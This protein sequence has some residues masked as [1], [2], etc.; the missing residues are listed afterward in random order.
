MD[1]AVTI[2]KI[3]SSEYDNDE[4]LELVHRASGGDMNSL[5][6]F[7]TRFSADIFNFPIKVFRLDEDAASDF[8]LYA[9]ERL[10]D[11]K[12]FKSFQGR[13]SFRTWFY[14]VLRNLLIDWMRTVRELKTVNFTRLDEDGNL[15]RSIE[16]TPDPRSI[17]EGFDKPQVAFEKILQSLGIESRV[18]FKLSYIY[19]LDLSED[20]IEYLLGKT[21]KGVPDL[22]K[23]I[24]NLKHFLSEK[25]LKNHEAEDKIT[26]LYLAII[27]LKARKEQII[28]E[29]LS[30]ERM[31]TADEN[32][33]LERIDRSLQKK[34]NQREKLLEKKG[35]G[36]FIV[37]TPY[38]YIS[39]LLDIPE[40]SISVQMMRIL[41]KVQSG[42]AASGF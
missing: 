3:R 22:L 32:F 25:E 1:Q 26:S 18:L 8:F 2:E 9:Y 39:E 23:Y 16:N 34:Y 33:E 30:M 35:K 7:F 19:Y 21:R 24:A 41:E 6:T 28:K 5:K 13:S 15:I 29:S 42:A 37:R 40:G 12:R 36:R 11:G 27:E 20:E 31:N 4:V 10:R 14:T 38:K 17:I